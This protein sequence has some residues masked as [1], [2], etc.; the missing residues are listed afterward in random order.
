MCLAVS[1]CEK[2]KCELCRFSEQDLLLILETNFS[3]RKKKKVTV[4]I[5]EMTE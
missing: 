1:G 4:L 3:Q 2:F 5:T